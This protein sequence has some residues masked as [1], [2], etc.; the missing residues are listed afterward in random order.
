MVTRSFKESLNC[1]WINYLSTNKFS[2]LENAPRDG[3]VLF[4]LLCLLYFKG[5]FLFF[6]VNL[7]LI[8]FQTALLEQP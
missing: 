6:L 7:A 2:F 5:L 8:K 1:I 4:Y 3:S